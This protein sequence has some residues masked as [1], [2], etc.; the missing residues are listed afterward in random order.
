MYEYP[1]IISENMYGYPSISAPVPQDE[2]KRKFVV[3]HTVLT[4]LRLLNP[5]LEPVNILREEIM[6]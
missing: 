5:D 4:G 2:S 6:L 1:S 3:C